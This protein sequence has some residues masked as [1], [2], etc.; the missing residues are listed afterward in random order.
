MRWLI[1]LL[2]TL[3]LSCV[4]SGSELPIFI[5]DFT[6]ESLLVH[7]KPLPSLDRFGGS[8]KEL[9][10]LNDSTLLI[11]YDDIPKVA[12]VGSNLEVRN[13]IDLA[14]PL[15]LNPP[16]LSSA[17]ML[18]DSLIYIANQSGP[19]IEII[20]LDGRARERIDLDFIPGSLASLGDT[21]LITPF[22]VGSTP[23]S[24]LYMSDRRSVG[25]LKA[26]PIPISRYRDPLARTLANTVRPTVLAD[27]HLVLTHLVI[28]PFAQLS[29]NLERGFER[30]P[31][32]LP[33]IVQDRYGWLPTAEMSE[34]EA[35]E[36]LVVAIAA[37]PDLE[38]GDLLYL[39]QT[40]R[41]VGSEGEKGIIRVD[42]RLR[43]KRSYI[44]DVNARGLAYLTESKSSIV[45]TMN[46]GW[47]RCETP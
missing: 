13:E 5:D 19:E 37:T 33:D 45:T 18:G 31:L 46:D 7:C 35:E 17:T 23:S 36:I 9:R 32:P 21:L 43:Y 2:S 4:E 11:L 15:S 30:V 29:D 1:L 3:T 12:L 27:G 28:V 38:S 39:T 41:R 44:I 10:T 40:G 26:L 47:F 25:E 16:I 6:E 14:Q 22:V 42:N 20:D 8:V 34:E 24:L